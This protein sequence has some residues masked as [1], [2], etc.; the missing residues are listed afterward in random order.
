ME[1]FKDLSLDTCFSYTVK[2]GQKTE[3]KD[4]LQPLDNKRA[5]TSNLRNE[6]C[7]VIPS[8]YL[9]LLEQQG[10]TSAYTLQSKTLYIL[11]MH[12]GHFAQ[13]I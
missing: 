4:Y 7:K 10:K 8:W 6:D 3:A 2:E 12:F 5:I 1:Y 9:I 13:N 11:F